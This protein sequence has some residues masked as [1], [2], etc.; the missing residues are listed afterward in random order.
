METRSTYKVTYLDKDRQERFQYAFSNGLRK[1]ISN[2]KKF[3]KA[4]RIKTDRMN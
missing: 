3:E 4:T 1:L 2:L